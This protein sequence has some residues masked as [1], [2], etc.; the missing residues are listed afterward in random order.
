MHRPVATRVSRDPLKASAGDPY[1]DRSRPTLREIT[2]AD[3]YGFNPRQLSRILD[4]VN[5]D[6]IRRT[7]DE[8]FADRGPL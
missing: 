4:V 6:T 1:S 3:S 2:I 8:H 5:R 7:W